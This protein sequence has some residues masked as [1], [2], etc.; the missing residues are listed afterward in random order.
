MTFPASPFSDPRAVPNVKPRET[1]EPHW[2][3][4]QLKS[5]FPGVELALF[6]HFGVGSRERSGFAA[7]ERLDDLLRRHLIFDAEKA[8]RRLDALAAEDWQHAVAPQTL[9]TELPNFV[10]IDA[11]SAHEYERCH[12][13][14]SRLLSAPVVAQLRAIPPTNLVVVCADGSQSPSASRHLR[15]FGLPAQH[16]DGGLVGWSISCDESFPINYPLREVPGRWHL[17]ADGETLRYRRVTAVESEWRVWTRQQLT[18]NSR[19]QTLLQTLPTLRMV[20]VT[21]HSFALR[22]L[23]TDL[24]QAVL[25]A[26]PLLE[27]IELWNSGGTS[28]DPDQEKEILGH[29]LAEEAKTILKSHKGTVEIASYQDRRLELRLGGGC[30]GCASAQ[31]TTQRELAAALYREVPLLD[32]ISSAE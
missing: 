12:I 19:L 23:P 26:S 13:P 14:E 20:M 4:G 11:R 10:V 28:S 9:E 1:V 18:E 2:T 6:A 27:E 30:A 29:V 31:I 8:C 25:L 24:R 7:S 5:T 21:P 17:L 32:A 16:L 22:G 3:L 15:S